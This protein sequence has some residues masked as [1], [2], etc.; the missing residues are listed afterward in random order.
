MEIKSVPSFKSLINSVRNNFIS[1]LELAVVEPDVDEI[2]DPTIS[3]VYITLFQREQKPLRWGAKR[4]NLEKTLQRIILK[5]KQN[6]RYPE[7]E[8]ANPK[9][10]RIMIE[11]VVKQSPCD[12][13]ELTALQISPNRF[14]PGINGLK[15]VYQEIGRASCR[16]RV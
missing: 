1:T 8:I 4:E 3:Q 16:E 15:Y 9:A 5:L 2:F 13:N 12:I 7:F 14:E 6:P 10:C 11:I